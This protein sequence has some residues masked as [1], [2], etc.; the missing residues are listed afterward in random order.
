MSLSIA[1]VRRH[2][3]PPILRARRQV[4][5]TLTANAANTQAD[6]STCAQ[7]QLDSRGNRSASNPECWE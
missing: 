2:R 3:L 4:G 1:P 6:D 7:M 5:F